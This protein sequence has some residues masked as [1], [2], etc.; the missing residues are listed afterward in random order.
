[1]HK[2]LIGLFCVA[3]MVTI[4]GCG[5]SKPPLTTVTGTV[6]YDGKPLERATVS[7]TPDGGDGTSKPANGITD[8]DGNFTLTTIFPDGE[9]LEGASEG[10]YTVRVTKLIEIEMPEGDSGPPSDD[11]DPSAEMMEMMGGID[12]DGNP[13]IDTAE[14]LINETFGLPYTITPAWQNKCTIGSIETATALKITLSSNGT[15]TVE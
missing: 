10:T 11:E 9:I 13:M 8:S 15:G 7:L 2:K 3:L 5:S 4:A 1:M 6:S 12:E 14:S